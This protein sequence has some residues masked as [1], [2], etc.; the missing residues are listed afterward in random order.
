M[1][2]FSLS[3]LDGV[4][5]YKKLYS[6]TYLVL[7]IPLNHIF[8]VTKGALGPG[9]Q[10]VDQ[11]LELFGRLEGLGS[12]PG[13]EPNCRTG[14]LKSLLLNLILGMVFFEFILVVVNVDVVVP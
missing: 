14:F 4:Y 2:L 5:P 13:G 7:F 9:V 8:M 6:Y 12:N 3:S 10:N 1:R 11:L